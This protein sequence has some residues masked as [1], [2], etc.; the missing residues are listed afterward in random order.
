MCAESAGYVQERL[1]LLPKEFKRFDNPHV[2]K[3]GLSPKLKKLKDEL[4]QQKE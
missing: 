3:V 1:D 2:Y 4:I